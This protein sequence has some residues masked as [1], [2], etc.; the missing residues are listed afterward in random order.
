[1]ALIENWTELQKTWMLH[2]KL[3]GKAADFINNDP[4]VVNVNDFNELCKV[5]QTKFT[6]SKNLVDL[7]KEF[8]N[9][10]HEPK[11]SVDDLARK[12][13][14]IVQKYIPNPRDSLEIEVIRS[15]K[16]FFK[17]METLRNDIRD[18]SILPEPST[19][20]VSCRKQLDEC[21]H[22]LDQLNKAI[23]KLTEQ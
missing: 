9:I 19:L 18:N 2:N 16:I 8:S 17:F 7:Q 13:D 4:S 12:I 22:Q 1:M 11:Q 23:N 6:K 20:H 21:K 10:R 15:N 3:S 14:N 5:L